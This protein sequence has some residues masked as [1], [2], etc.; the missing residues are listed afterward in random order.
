MI[1]L[2]PLKDGVK[3]NKKLTFNESQK[4][5]RYLTHCKPK[6]NKILYKYVKIMLGNTKLSASFAPAMREKFF[7]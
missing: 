7:I 3:G 1:L 6:A 2:F 4:N 5:K